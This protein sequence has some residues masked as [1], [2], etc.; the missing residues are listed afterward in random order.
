MTYPVD[1]EGV[2][3]SGPGGQKSAT[4]KGEKGGGKEFLPVRE[5]AP[6]G[7]GH[8][9][10]VSRKNRSLRTGTGLNPIGVEKSAA[11]LRSRLPPTAPNPLS[12]NLQPKRDVRRSAEANLDDYLPSKHSYSAWRPCSTRPRSR[13]KAG[14]PFRAV[15]QFLTESSIL[16]ADFRRHRTAE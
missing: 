3:D 5:W 9:G 15:H 11:F 1:Q 7:R 8:R 14:M 4:P 13:A 6:E 12:H 2:G 10:P 16:R